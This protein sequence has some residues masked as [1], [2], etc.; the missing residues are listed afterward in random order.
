ML[1][2]GFAIELVLGL[3]YAWSVFVLPLE[4]EF[5]WI[6]AQTSL[7]FTISLVFFPVGM[8][9][10]GNL[11]DRH[12]LR[13]VGSLSAILLASG[14][15]LTSF[16]N[17][18]AWLVFSFGVIGGLG[19]GACSNTTANLLSWFDERRGLA[20]GVLSTGFGLGGLVLGS[21]ADG[22]ITAVGWRIAFRILSG[23]AFV[24]CFGGF[25]F[26]RKAPTRTHSGSRAQ[27]GSPG[28]LDY[29]PQEMLR[30][31]TF[32]LLSLWSLLVSTAGVMVIGH[33]VPLAVELG[34]SSSAAVLALGALSLANGLG[35]LFYGTLSDRLGR[36]P[37]MFLGALLMGLAILLAIPVTR[38]FDLPGLVAAALLV[39]SS[40]GG[41]VP[42]LQATVMHLFGT[43]HY[44]TNLGLGSAQIA[45]SGL[46]GPQ[47]AGFL[48]SSTGSYGLPF[49][50]TGL[51]ALGACLVAVLF[52]VALQRMD[53]LV[54]RSL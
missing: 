19:I 2:I 37:T 5:G 8:F 36:A 21:L 4:A 32:W 26:L 28:P 53:Q 7:A 41:M 45:L 31:P 27:Q 17:S 34:I 20:A 35:R 46:L 24:I 15:L 6:R 16:T 22:L 42:L 23:I 38:G 48:R 29:E 3:L 47:M 43:K 10:A 33:M 12:G 49:A 52:G 1:V 13:W 18:V 39:G 11:A 14:F 25:Q 30:A 44:G 40:Y 54:A 50:V 9:L 51:L